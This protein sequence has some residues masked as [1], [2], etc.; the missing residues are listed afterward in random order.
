[1]EVA[2]F[3]REWIIEQMGKIL[4]NMEMYP[5]VMPSECMNYYQYMSNEIMKF[6]EKYL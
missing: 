5:E 1:L 2:V 6:S 4:L 3:I